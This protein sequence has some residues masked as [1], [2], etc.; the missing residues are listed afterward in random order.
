MTLK[1]AAAVV[2]Y[3]EMAPQKESGEHS[4][5]GII[6][7]MASQAARDAQIDPGDIDGLLVAASFMEYAL[8]W[9]SQVS[10]YLGMQPRY[11]DQVELGG[12]SA[13]GMLWRAAAAIQGGLCRHVLCVM[14]DT[15]D[16]SKGLSL[17][18]HPIEQ[19]FNWP[20]GLLGAN[21]SYALI[22]RR[23]M[24]E[25]GTTPEQ[26]A[27]VA[28]D[29][30][31]NAQANPAALFGNKPLSIDDVLNSRLIVDPLHLYEIV[32]PC[33]GGGAFIVSKEH[34]G[35]HRPVHLLGAGE[36]A[37]HASIAHAQ[38]LTSTGV[39][40]A[41]SQ[42]FAMAGLAPADM[43]FVQPY[44]CYTIAVILTLEDAGFCPKGEGG[45]FV[46]EHDLTFRGDFPCNTHGGQLSF[47]QPGLA[48]G[49]SHVLEAVRQLMGRAG[50]RQLKEPRV[51]YVN[52]NGGMMSEEVSL[53]LGVE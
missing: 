48:G 12:A 38:S 9:P 42:A 17:P 6:G 51:G 50:K 32:S 37:G 53:I 23:H 8:L 3:A 19:E 45:R 26:L 34:R 16:L 29:Q 24:H 22:A 2:G 27:K 4:A 35:P 13:A 10:E 40:P 20:Y 30:R 25:F 36:C 52:G 5:L 28:V 44:D 46:M 47:G 15:W 7:Q 11:L 33:T 39:G 14:G 43:D 31:S 21:P 49:L 1:Q 18:I 41:A